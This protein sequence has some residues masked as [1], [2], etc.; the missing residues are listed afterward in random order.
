M[1][2]KKSGRLTDQELDSVCGGGLIYEY[3]P[4][5]AYDGEPAYK[6]LRRDAAGIVRSSMVCPVVSFDRWK[7]GVIDRYGVCDLT[8]IDPPAD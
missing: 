2:R 8:R 3:Y 7:Q 1:A 6:I 5:T 4:V